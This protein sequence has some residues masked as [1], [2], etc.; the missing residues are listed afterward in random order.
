MPVLAV[1]ASRDAATIART[2]IPGATHKVQTDHAALVCDAEVHGNTVVIGQAPTQST[3][4]LAHDEIILQRGAA[5]SAPIYYRL[6]PFCAASSNMTPLIQPGDAI[7]FGRLASTIGYVMHHGETRT[8]YQNIH[9]V[10]PFETVVL[11]SLGRQIVARKPPTVMHI[12]NRSVDSLANELRE[13][14]FAAVARAAGN[15]TVG[16]LLGGLDSSG[17]LAALLAMRGAHPDEITQ[18]TLDFDAPGSDRP[19]VRALERHFGISVARIS[20]SYVSAERALVVD[21]APSRHSGDVGTVECAH[22]LRVMGAQ[23][24]MTGTGGDELFG[25]DFFTSVK[26][27]LSQG[28]VAG[29][30]DV[31]RARFPYPLSMRSRVRA[32]GVGLAR[33]YV[34]RAIMRRRRRAQ[35]RHRAPPWAGRVL[36]AEIERALAA[37]EV[38][39]AHDAQ[40]RYDAMATNPLNSELGAEVRAQFDTVTPIPRCDP[41]YD[42][43]LVQFLTALPQQT[44]FAGGE[45]RGLLRRALQGLLPESVRLRP[46]KSRFEPALADAIPMGKLDALLAFEALGDAG[47]VI[48]DRMREFFGPLYKAPHDIDVGDRWVAFWPAVTTEAFLR[49]R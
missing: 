35:N 16:L 28:D 41:L 30:W 19:H 44:L 25:G 23:I 45:W 26:E 31:M 32:V 1:C 17:I 7:D 43:E 14:L 34:P 3:I 5:W 8:V 22:H 20:P 42:E 11:S 33:P 37:S 47:L 9:Q 12:A 36:Q 10:R 27:G 24:F 38:N 2:L 18:V 29:F 40:S 49:T 48:P 46:D 15:R 4:A 21:G 13:R 6:E 39:E